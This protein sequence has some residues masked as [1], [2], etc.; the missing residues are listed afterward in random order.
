[1]ENK[2]TSPKPWPSPLVVWKR[3]PVL[4]RFFTAVKLVKEM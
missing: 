2:T 4:L 1:M 3:P